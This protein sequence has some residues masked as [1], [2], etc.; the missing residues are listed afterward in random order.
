MAGEGTVY[1]GPTGQSVSKE[2][3]IEHFRGWEP[4]VESLTQVCR[5]NFWFLK[6]SLDAS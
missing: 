4:E 1:E 6:T 3:V 2:E 5:D